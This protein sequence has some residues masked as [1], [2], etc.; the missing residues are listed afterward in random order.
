MMKS[1]FKKLAFVMALAMVVSAMAPAA[2]A[3]AADVE[4]LGICLQD[5]AT[6]TALETDEM[7]VGNEARDYRFAG[8]PKN[9]KDYK[10]TWTSSDEKVAVVDAKS[11]LV[12]AVAPG[13]TTIKVASDDN[14][15]VGELALTVKAKEVVPAY[16]VKQTAS[17]KVTITW[18]DAKAATDNVT[19]YKVYG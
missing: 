19:L 11:G 18:A 4:K 7:T 3:K 10:W 6:W 2:T 15:Y 5:D 13:T 9:W 14:A 8:A 1:F 12:A 16:V 17:N